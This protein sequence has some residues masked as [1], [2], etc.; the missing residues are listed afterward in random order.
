MVISDELSTIVF[1]LYWVSCLSY[2][3]F[4]V[5]YTIS[6]TDHCRIFVEALLSYNYTAI[7]GR[8]SLILHAHSYECAFFGLVLSKVVSVY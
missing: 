3:D 6:T 1:Q 4:N 2:C 5:Y 8:V 7:I